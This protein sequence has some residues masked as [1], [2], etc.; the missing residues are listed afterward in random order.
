MRIMISVIIPT[1]NEKENIKKLIL[2]IIDV[3]R[4]N[5]LNG[6]IIIVDDNSPDGT[7]EIAEMLAKKY[8]QKYPIK[9]I[10]RKGK[11]GLASAVIEGFNRSKGNILGVMD[12][13]LSHLPSAIPSLVKPI[14]KGIVDFTIGSRYVNNGKIIGWPFLRTLIS[15]GATLI[16]RHLASVKDPMSGYFFIKRSV[17]DNTCLNA[18]GYKICLEILVKGNYSKVMEV[19]ITFKD[20]EKGSSKLNKQEFIDYLYNVANLSIYK[21]LRRRS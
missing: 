21:L 4:A 8:S 2:K 15:K 5:K 17:I 9:V 6:E 20:R 16:A 12:A 14:E 13:D 19:P 11:L 3:F 1:Y 18:H 10:H 7:G